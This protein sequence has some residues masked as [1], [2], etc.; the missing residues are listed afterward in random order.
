MD[1]KSGLN[2]TQSTKQE[3]KAGLGTGKLSLGVVLSSLILPG[4]FGLLFTG[5]PQYVG[6]YMQVYLVFMAIDAVVGLVLAKTQ[7]FPEIFLLLDC[8]FLLAVKAKRIKD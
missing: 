4:V 7:K 5:I 8:S 3:S 2:K 6:F 1:R